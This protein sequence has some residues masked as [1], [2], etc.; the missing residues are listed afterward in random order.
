MSCTDQTFE[1]P[2]IAWRKPGL[3]QEKAT[4][5]FKIGD[6]FLS[7]LPQYTSIIV[8]Q[9]GQGGG[10]GGVRAFVHCQVQNKLHRDWEGLYFVCQPLF[11]TD[12]GYMAISA[13]GTNCSMD[14]LS[15]CSCNAHKPSRDQARPNGMQWSKISLLRASTSKLTVLPST[16]QAEIQ[17]YYYSLACQKK[18]LTCTFS[19]TKFLLERYS[20]S[21][22]ARS[23]PEQ[24]QEV[25]Q[26]Y[27]KGSRG[28]KATLLSYIQ[29]E[30]SS[31]PLG[32]A[33]RSDRSPDSDSRRAAL[34]AFNHGCFQE[35]GLASG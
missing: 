23:L 19:L 33:S 27:P 31:L 7:L 14:T 26:T 30:T 11:V 3:L 2:I 34:I 12:L 28:G 35:P 15:C 6:P 1:T 8:M 29:L 5:G 16:D 18:W 13:T 32:P 25:R 4:P 17:M 24:Q 10:G 21:G 9:A 22:T 20:A